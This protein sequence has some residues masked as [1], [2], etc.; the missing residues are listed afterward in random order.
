M[1]NQKTEPRVAWSFLF[2]WWLANTVGFIIAVFAHFP[3]DFRNVAE[4]REFVW[5]T[6]LFSFMLGMFFAFPVG[7]FQ[8][9]VLRRW[10]AVSKFWILATAIGVGFTHALNDATP[11]SISLEIEMLAGSVFVGI[12]QSLVLKKFVP[13][14]WSFLICVVAWFAAWQ[15]G[16]WV[17]VSTGLYFLTW[18]SGRSIEMK[19]A[20]ALVFGSVYA[21]VTGFGLAFWLQSQKMKTEKQAMI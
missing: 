6:A 13:A 18:E 7:I 21:L 3:G 5:A 11:H 8:W 1:T 17:I 2:W 20:F 19:F 12:V 10:L 16:L 4:I 14:R 15:I 9:L